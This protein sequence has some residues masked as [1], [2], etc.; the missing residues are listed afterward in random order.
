MRDN[1]TFTVQPHTPCLPV[2]NF[3]GYIDR[4]PSFLIDYELPFPHLRAIYEVIRCVMRVERLDHPE[5]FAASDSGNMKDIDITGLVA[6]GVVS[7]DQR[8]VPDAVVRRAS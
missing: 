3:D 1:G 6:D 8:V 7:Y 2:G 4:E 5:F